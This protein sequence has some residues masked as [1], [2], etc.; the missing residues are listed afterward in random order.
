MQDNTQGTTTGDTTGTT[1]CTYSYATI[2]GTVDSYPVIT[3]S[4]CVSVGDLTALTAASTSVPTTTP[5]WPPGF[6]S[7][8]LVIGFFVLLTF[9]TLFFDFILDRV[10]GVKLRQQD[11]F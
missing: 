10:I 11:R 5:A 1:T 4:T 9:C 7:G 6:S 3:G 2:P 8:E